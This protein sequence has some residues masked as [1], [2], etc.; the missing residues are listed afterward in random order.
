MDFQ[1]LLGQLGASSNPMGMIM[2]MLPQNQK[3]LFSNVANAKTDEERAQI[4]ANICN[5]NGITKEQLQN[6][7]NNQKF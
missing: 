2:N 6:A 4:I 7:L 5:Q 1:N 3:G